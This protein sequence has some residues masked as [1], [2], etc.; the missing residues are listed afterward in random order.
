MTVVFVLP[1]VFGGGADLS[2]VPPR[3][4]AVAIGDGLALN[5]Q[6]V[7]EGTPVVLVHGLPSNIGDWA[8]LPERLAALG[9]R[10]VVYDRVGYG[11]SSRA[12][13]GA[14]AYTIPAN[15]RQ[16]G[17]LLDS[18]GIER[19][20]LV[21]WSYG[22][23]IVQAFAAEHPERVSK[24]VLLGSVGPTLDDEGSDPIDAI[25]ESPIG[26]A[27]F[28]WVASVPPVAESLVTGSLADMFSGAEHVPPGFADRTVAQLALPGTMDAW[29]AE[30][31]NE[32]YAAL[33]PEWIQA[34]T[35]VIHGSDDRAVTVGVA[36]DLAKRLPHGKLELVP[37]GS[38]ML[39]ATHTDELAAQIHEWAAGS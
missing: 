21:G 1:L 8:G 11:W 38:H 14:D 10:V 19:A 18:L 23:G 37:Q 27:V 9:H 17:Q 33:H 36:E 20:A 24:L 28:R 34:P 2:T 35:L 39:P 22:G 3:A 5:V 25:A 6:E 15:A 7:G 32:G 29:L 12:A 26:P 31:R 30:S 4:R 13:E 16:L